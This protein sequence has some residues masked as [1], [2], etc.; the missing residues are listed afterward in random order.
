MER[1]FSVHFQHFLFT[2]LTYIYCNPFH[3]LENEMKIKK[4]KEMNGGKVK[5]HA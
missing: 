3:Q 4:L 5:F 2:K 1:V